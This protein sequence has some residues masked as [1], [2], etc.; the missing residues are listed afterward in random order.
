MAT[1]ATTPVPVHRRTTC[2]MVRMNPR[3]REMLRRCAEREAVNPSELLRALLRDFAR[4][5]E[6]DAAEQG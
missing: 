5:T 1:R 4:T 6:R 3:E 2:V